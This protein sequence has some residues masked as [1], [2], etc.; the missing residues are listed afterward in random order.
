M[1]FSENLIKQLH[2][3]LL[4]FSEKDERH[5]GEYKKLP[6]SVEAFDPSGKSLG[7]IF[8]TA[9]PFDIPIQHEMQN[10]KSK[11]STK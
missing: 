1:N 10:E 8:E 6:N 11:I 4:K 5:S 3:I 2:G 9:S 7:I